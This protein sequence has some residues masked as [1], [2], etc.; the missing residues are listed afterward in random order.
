MM[1]RMFMKKSY[2]TLDELK[3]SVKQ[4]AGCHGAQVCGP[5]VLFYS[6]RAGRP[7]SV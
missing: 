4:R 2:Q 1:D 6:A 3:G 7:L 5:V